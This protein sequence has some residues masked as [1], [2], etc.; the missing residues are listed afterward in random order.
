VERLRAAAGCYWVAHLHHGRLF[1]EHIADSDIPQA[2]L[3]LWRSLASV[4]EV[5]SENDTAKGRNSSEPWQ[6]RR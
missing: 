6:K 2:T 5:H 4:C 3:F 1:T